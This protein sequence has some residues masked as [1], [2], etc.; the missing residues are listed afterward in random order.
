MVRMPKTLISKLV[1]FVN[2]AGVIASGIPRAIPEIERWKVK[3][4]YQASIL[5]M[6][7]SLYLGKGHPISSNYEDGIQNLEAIDL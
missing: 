4:I 5:V 3:V 7:I 2:M 6:S 1:E